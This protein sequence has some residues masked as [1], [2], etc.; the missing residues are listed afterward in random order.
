MPTS[1]IKS[2]I[3][4]FQSSFSEFFAAISLRTAF[5]S[6]DA[7]AAAPPAAPAA[8][9]VVVPVFPVA[10]A[11]GGVEAVGAPAVGVV[12]EEACVAEPP[13]KIFDIS[14][15]NSFIRR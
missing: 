2:T 7:G 10:P 1:F 3:D 13:P 4:F 8:G 12:A 6:T 5:T 9:I 11:A 15:L 14:L